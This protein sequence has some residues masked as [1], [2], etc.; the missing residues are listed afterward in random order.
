VGRRR[1]E[2]E[3]GGRT[4]RIERNEVGYPEESFRK[5]GQSVDVERV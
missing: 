4:I 2:E 3:G 1:K 5:Y